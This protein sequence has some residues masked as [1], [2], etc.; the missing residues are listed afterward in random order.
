MGSRKELYIPLGLWL[1]YTD[2]FHRRQPLQL[3][4][5]VCCRLVGADAGSETGSG[6]QPRTFPTGPWQQ[7]HAKQ[8]PHHHRETTAGAESMLQFALLSLCRLLFWPYE[9]SV[10]KKCALFRILYNWP[11]FSAVNIGWA[12][13]AR[14][15][16]LDLLK[17]NFHRLSNIL[18]PSWRRQSTKWLSSVKGQLF[19]IKIARILNFYD[20]CILVLWSC[21]YN[22]LH[23]HVSRWRVEHWLSVHQSAFICS[24]KS[25]HL[26]NAY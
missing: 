12:L 25:E 17:H 8:V 3:R 6:W 19:W 2:I 14:S 1:S 9:L 15:D 18:L 23:L 7:T 21:Y 16:F 26:S 11:F 20:L 10:L 22:N 13:F 4:T 5:G 24:K